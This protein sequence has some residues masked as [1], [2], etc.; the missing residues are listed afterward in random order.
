MH[1]LLKL[2]L[3]LQAYGCSLT[4]SPICKVCPI[5][6]VPQL[7]GAWC[8][9]LDCFS[10]SSAS[11]ILVNIEW[12]VRPDLK[13]TLMSNIFTYSTN[14]GSLLRGLMFFLPFSLDVISHQQMGVEVKMK[15][16]GCSFCFNTLSRWSS[17]CR[18]S[19]R[20]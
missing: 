20:Y 7:Q 9:T 10:N 14:V 11:F 1:A 6:T 8:T 16:A 18:F 15:A 4:W 3:P 17:I 13:M 5:Y 2:I 12:S 19:V